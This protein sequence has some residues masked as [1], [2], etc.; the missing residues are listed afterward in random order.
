MI[1]HRL[2][3]IRNADQILVMDKGRII[4]R[5]TWDDLSKAGGTFASLLEA[6]HDEGA[7]LPA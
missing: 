5:G 3:T 7:V 2:S 4:E 1:A 6:Q